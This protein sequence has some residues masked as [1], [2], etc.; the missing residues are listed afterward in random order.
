MQTQLDA[1]RTSRDLDIHLLGVNETGYERDNAINC[2]GRDIPWLQETAD[3]LV[4]E[5]WEV[6]YRDVIIVDAENRRLAVFNLS[7]YDL[8]HS[9]N[10][11]SLKTLLLEF[12]SE[13]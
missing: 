4:W 11:D 10:Y 5:P 8:D 12:A 6:E 2:E 1:R 9:A 3:E 7:T 13:P